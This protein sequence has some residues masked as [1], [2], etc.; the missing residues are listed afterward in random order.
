VELLQGHGGGEDVAVPIQQIAA[1]PL[2]L[3]RL[4]ELGLRLVFELRVWQERLEP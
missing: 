2:V 4:F 1:T 3:D